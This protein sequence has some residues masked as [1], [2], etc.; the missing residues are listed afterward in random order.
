MPVAPF[1]S[2]ERSTVHKLTY[3]MSEGGPVVVED[4]GGG[5]SA[6][7][8]GPYVMVSR[9]CARATGAVQL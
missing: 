8:P 6:V 3:K 2:Y 5:G 7:E 1:F 9:T 4:G